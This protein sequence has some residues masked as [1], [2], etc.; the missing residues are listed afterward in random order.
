MASL[1][2]LEVGTPSHIKPNTHG[3]VLILVK[4]KAK[5][6]NFTTINTPPW[7][8]KVDILRCYL[9]LMTNFFQG[10]WWSKNPTIWL[11]E[12]IFAVNLWPKFSQICSF[13]GNLRHRSYFYFTSISAKSNDTILRKKTQTQLLDHF[14]PFLVIF[15]WKRLFSENLT[16]SRTTLYGSLTQSEFQK[17]TNVSI[18]RKPQDREKNG[19][20]DPNSKDPSHKNQGSNKYLALSQIV[21][22]KMGH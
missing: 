10:Y 20:K 16:Q 7:V 15:V 4:L 5:A 17:K 12:S 6:C 18:P 11:D 22:K 9:S 2:Y 19:R 3:G 8:F 21:C 1:V 13:L 14:W